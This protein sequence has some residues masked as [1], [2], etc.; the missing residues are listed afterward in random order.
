VADDL[1]PDRSRAPAPARAFVALGSNQGDRGAHLRRALARLRATPGVGQVEPS[2]VYETDPVG[3]P[4][5]GR[6][7][8]AVASVV[9]TLAPRALL[10]RLLAI[11]AAEGRVRGAERNAPRPLDLDLLLHGDACLKEPGL[12]VPHPRLHERAFVL[13]PLCD[14][15]PEL[16]HPRLGATVREL[17]GRVRGGAGVRRYRNPLERGGATMAIAAVSIAPV[18]EGPSVGA[19]VAEALRVLEGQDLVRFEVGPMFTTLEGELGDILAVVARMHEALF[20]RGARR[21][22]TVLKIDERR[23][24]AVHMEDK[25]RSVE[26]ALGRERR[27]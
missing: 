15:A 16:R 24:R 8:N 14:L 7:L 22:S 10:E 17:L 5:Q 6:F 4:P 25:V 19:W 12:E 13:A 21:V 18:G 9:T 23:D 3:G 20:A 26:D 2:P 1:R 27:R 11:E